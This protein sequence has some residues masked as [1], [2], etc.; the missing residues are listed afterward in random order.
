MKKK[1]VKIILQAIVSAL[2]AVITA[3]SVTSCTTYLRASDVEYNG[4][5]GNHTDSI[6]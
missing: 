3:L 4:S 1:I 2:T 5:I 6:K